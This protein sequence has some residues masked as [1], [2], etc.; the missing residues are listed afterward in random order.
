M[1]QS[2]Q[3]NYQLFK[4]SRQN[5]ACGIKYTS[6][7]TIENMHMSQIESGPTMPRSISRPRIEFGLHKFFE[8]YKNFKVTNSPKLQANLSID[9]QHHNRSISITSSAKLFEPLFAMREHILDNKN[10][11]EI[12]E[13]A[14][15]YVT[16]RDQDSQK[17]RFSDL[18]NDNRKSMKNYMK[19]THKKLISRMSQAK[20]NTESESVLLKKEDLSLPEDNGFQSIVSFMKSLQ[21]IIEH[22][23]EQAPILSQYQTERPTLNK[24]KEVLKPELSEICEDEDDRQTQPTT[25]FGSGTQ[26]LCV[27]ETRSIC[28][29]QSIVSEKKSEPETE[30]Y[31]ICEKP[32]AGRKLR[33]SKDTNALK[34]KKSLTK[35]NQDLKMIDEMREVLRMKK[36]EPIAL[37]PALGV[38]E[39]MRGKLSLA[40]VK[41]V[42]SSIIPSKFCEYDM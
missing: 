6:H 21:G 3:S 10:T 11:E 34:L 27:S 37:A 4:A 18:G 38:N 15:K 8:N 13:I 7:K 42:E 14:P 36:N 35:A 26:V 33:P 22:P 2:Q 40:D 17:G 23:E 1:L 9:A 12:R 24:T 5:K 31:Q 20:K 41:F 29:G 16:E 39:F 19:I 32:K 30:Y 25:K 28:T